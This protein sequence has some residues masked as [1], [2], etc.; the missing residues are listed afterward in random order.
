ML[1]KLDSKLTYR[2]APQR[3]ETGEK[4]APPY[5]KEERGVEDGP[6]TQVKKYK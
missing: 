2:M 6:I 1:S 4:R 5:E 3:L